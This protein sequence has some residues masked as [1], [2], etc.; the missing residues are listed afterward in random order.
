MVAMLA[1]LAGLVLRLSTVTREVADIEASIS[2]ASNLEKLIV[3][4]ETG[5]RAFLL[6][7]G[8]DFLEPTQWADAQLPMRFRELRATVPDDPRQLGRLDRLERSLQE[9]RLLVDQEIM[10]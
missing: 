7:A 4:A 9:W 5:F 3:D 2:I 6:V 1:V 10:A 8:D